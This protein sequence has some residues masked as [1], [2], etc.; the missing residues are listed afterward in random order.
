M[1][2]RAAFKYPV[3]GAHHCDAQVQRLETVI[4]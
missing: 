2:H 4:A 1:L 3:S